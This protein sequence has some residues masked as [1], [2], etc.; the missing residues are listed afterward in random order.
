MT[1][2]PT[3]ADS[4]T[5]LESTL[6]FDELPEQMR[7]HAYGVAYACLTLP[8]GSQLFLTR[9]GWPWR[10]HLLPEHW[11]NDRQLAR[12]GTRLKWSTGHVYRISSQAPPRPMDLVVKCSRMAQ[13]VPIAPM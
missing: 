6:S 2:A 8:D 7:L 4:P 13:H 10:R 9:Y 11:Y 3:A 5:A 1:L 12:R